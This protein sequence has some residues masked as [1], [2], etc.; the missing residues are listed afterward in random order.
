VPWARHFTAAHSS[1]QA[2]QRRF[3]APDTTRSK[4]PHLAL[5]QGRL[6]RLSHPGGEP[7][8]GPPRFPV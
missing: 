4:N 7:L 1:A 8:V 2:Q 6:A 5:L 3:A